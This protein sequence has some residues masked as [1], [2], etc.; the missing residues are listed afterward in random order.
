MIEMGLSRHRCGQETTQRAAACRH[1]RSRITP[2]EPSW[3]GFRRHPCRR[4]TTSRSQPR[5]ATSTGWLGTTFKHV[6]LRESPA[7]A[8]ISAFT[9]ST[10]MPGDPENAC[11][12]QRFQHNRALNIQPVMLKFNITGSGRGVL[13][14]DPQGQPRQHPT[15]ASVRTHA[16]QATIVINSYHVVQLATQALDEVRREHWNELRAGGQADIAKQ[17]KDSRWCTITGE[18]LNAPGRIRT[19]DPRLRRTAH[20]PRRRGSA[21][22]SAVTAA[23]AMGTQPPGLRP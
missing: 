14:K 1:P 6:S 23:L 18:I 16:P 4:A 20:D 9:V 13:E 10:L 15:S 17:F 19:C 5:S 11:R 3:L 22:S 12:E 8:R 21:A 2:T 7:Q